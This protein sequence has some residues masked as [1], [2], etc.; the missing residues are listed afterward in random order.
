MPTPIKYK[1]PFK[2]DCFYHLVCK[3]IDGLLLFKDHR[4][5]EV[6]LHRF[7]GFTH[8]IMDVW[9]YSMLSNHT[10][11]VIKIKPLDH[12]IENIKALR[13]QTVAMRHWLSQPT[14]EAL[15][16]TMIER[17]MNSFLVSFANY[18]NNKYARLGGLFQKPFKR[19]EIADE[20]DLQMT[21]IY[22][23]ANAQKH[24]IVRDFKGHFYS[25]Y[26]RIL[27]NDPSFVDV[28]NLL[29]FFEG[30]EKFI[31]AHQCQADHYYSSI[32]PACELE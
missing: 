7:H 9:C 11:Q 13:V 1:A 19:I 29:N 14:D 17:Q 8:H 27:C 10:H 6:F 28:T 4:D 31:S 26:A 23:H 30:R 22:V 5:F 18:T 32:G 20:N 12:V 3:S 25:S 16:D 21:I 2:S 15:L 24:K